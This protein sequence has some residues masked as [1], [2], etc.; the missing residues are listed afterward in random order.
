MAK[1]VRKVTCDS[2]KR[3]EMSEQSLAARLV[4][5]EEGLRQAMCGSWWLLVTSVLSP[6]L[7][8]TGF[9]HGVERSCSILPFH[10]TLGQLYRYT[11]RK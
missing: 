5:G 2:S 7:Y 6:Q 8:G 3:G 9:S 1:T 10:E 4:G 11:E